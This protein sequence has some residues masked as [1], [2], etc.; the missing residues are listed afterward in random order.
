MM[1]ARWTA[2]TAAVVLTALEASAFSPSGVGLRPSLRSASIATTCPVTMMAKKTKPGVKGGG[3][4]GSPD[5]K[6]QT[7]TKKAADAKKE[8][9]KGTKKQADDDLFDMIDSV[10]KGAGPVQT[11]VKNDQVAVEPPMGLGGKAVGN[12]AKGSVGKPLVVKKKSSAPAAEAGSPA[13]APPKPASSG[14]E[15]ATAA[16]AETTVA[17]D[18]AAKKAEAEAAAAA[19]KEAKAEAAADA[20]RAAESAAVAK[21]E[22][23]AKTVADKKIAAEVAAVAKKEAEVKAAADAKM[24]AE[25]EAEAV[26]KKAVEAKA[27]ADAKVAAV[28]AVAV[29]EREAEA[30]AQAV[31]AA[32]TKAD[33][34]WADKVA[35][36][37]REQHEKE[38]A[39]PIIDFKAKLEALAKAA[40]SRLGQ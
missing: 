8:V 21:K 19:K 37:K 23:E 34:D 31:A 29:A 14:K 16:T 28:E 26:V 4:F 2:A 3:G 18:V 35:A 36:Q 22:A 12:V 7:I 1:T 15:P 40:K 5:S 32:K 33:A 20:K 24:A 30:K 39:T 27:V 38:H 10:A 6:T 25:V 17:A 13:A 9:K 11:I